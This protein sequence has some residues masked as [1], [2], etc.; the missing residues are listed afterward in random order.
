MSQSLKKEILVRGSF[1]TW[2]AKDAAFLVLGIGFLVAGI[3]LYTLPQYRDICYY[4]L[5]ASLPFIIVVFIRT[6]LLGQFQVTH[7]Q[8]LWKTLIGAQKACNWDDI[9]FAG[10]EFKGKKKFLVT[11][12]NNGKKLRRFH[13]IKPLSAAGSAVLYYR[14]MDV[15]PELVF[16]LWE[17][18]QKGKRTYLQVNRT[19]KIDGHIVQKDA[20][21]M[22]L[23]ESKILYI[24]TLVEDNISNETRSKL[25]YIKIL[26]P[27]IAYPPDADVPT[28]SLV[29]SLLEANLPMAIRDGYIDQL[30]AENGGCLLRNY[31]HSGKKWQWL[32]EGVEVL[33]ERP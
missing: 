4:A 14:Y 10:F 2:D 11:L 3:Y 33:M 32:H 19:I 22:V 20:G 6:A 13:E 17:P 27:K 7:Q 8:L 31:Y 5:L 1:N 23:F 16:N 30:V 21:S 25:Q 26:P 29:E 24:P 15:L 28:H 12:R 18:Q 9:G